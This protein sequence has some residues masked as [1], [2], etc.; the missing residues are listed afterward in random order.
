MEGNIL[1]IK[2]LTKNY[3]DF[4]LTDIY[5]T[6]PYGCIM[7]MIGE[8]GAGKSTTIKAILGL[9]HADA[10]SIRIFGMDGIAEGE[11]IREDLGIVL[12]ELNLPSTFNGKEIEKMMSKVYK[13]WDSTIYYEYLEQ[14][15]INKNKKIKDY[16]KGMKIKAALAIAL[17]HQAKLL[18]LDEPT[19]G[20]DPSIREEVL[21][22]LREFILDEEHSVLISSHILSDLEK[23]SDYVALI[24]K[25][26]MVLCEEK[27]RLL[28]DYRILK[29]STESIKKAAEEDDHMTLLGIR[30]HN[31]GSEA[32]VKKGKIRLEEYHLIAEPATLEEIMIYMVKEEK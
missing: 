27:D 9:I 21:D 20:L 18:I 19:D 8:N 23:I 1:E 10:G 17:S 14:F 25:G 24:H 32:L 28:E 31:F 16:S 7:G 12:G 15:D 5:L 11:K 30:E 3:D 2:G 4:S 22:I 6:I 29:G 26:R 13:N